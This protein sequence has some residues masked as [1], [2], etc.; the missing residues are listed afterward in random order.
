[1]FAERSDR[2]IYL[3]VLAPLVLAATTLAAVS[4]VGFHVLSGARAYVGGESLWSKARSQTVAKLRA[5]SVLGPTAAACAPMTEWLAVPLGD[6]AARL[7]LDRP[8]P[9]IA[10]ARSGFERGGNLP[11]DADA[12]I[13]LY[14]Y[15]GSTPL[16]AEPVASWRQGD[17]LIEQ[18]R[19]VGARICASSPADRDL[20]PA[21]ADLREL[22]RLDGEFI[23]VE[24]RFSS[25]L[26]QA[27]LQTETFLR[28]AILLLAI[29][30]AGGSAW[31][32]IRSLRAQIR[33]RQ[34]LVDSNTR[35][36]LAAQGAGV[37]LFAWHP[38][39]DS[40]DLDS[41][42]RQIYGVD[43]DSSLPLVRSEIRGLIHPDD[44]A[45]LRRITPS[46]LTKTGPL[47]SR[48]RVF[49][50]DG[51]IRHVEAIGMF[52]DAGPEA[53]GRHMV[54]VIRDVTEEVAA[55]TLHA[56]KAAAE[57]SAQAR[58]EFLSRLSHELRT[59]LNAV[60]GIAQILDIDTQEPLT[61]QQRQRVQLILDSGWHLLRL[62][63]DVLDITSIDAGQV[64]VRIAP[65]ELGPVLRASLRLVEA[66]RGRHDVRIVDH[67]PAETPAVLADPQRL[68]QVFVNL[69]SNA[70]KYNTRGGELRLGFREDGDMVCLS[71]ADDGPGIESSQLV[72]LFQPF[73]RLAR[74]ADVQ[75]TGL[76]LVVVKLLVEQMKGGIEVAS[77]LGR[78]SIFTVR[79]RKAV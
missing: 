50:Q 16:L 29:T 77:E 48:F 11:G 65:V 9:D 41:R 68:Q 76:G 22:E 53:G 58:T 44:L 8:T 17:E 66:E 2:L 24:K 70:C 12:M 52:R 45:M 71:F 33:Q 60:L 5:R 54:G 21:L 20:A 64:S 49:H 61:P 35:W 25:S 59:P 39:D 27:S 46:S 18:L 4:I 73:R 28:I 47:R 42:A 67:W 6:R 63:D 38:E 56:Q 19:A 34:A 14:R 62:V 15:F 55:S 10:E 75:G 36:E 74:T 69:L 26:G 79:L 13:D 23:A 57:R 30:L 78:G 3:R 51:S 72:E 40:T 1:M 31:Y 32:V 43:A 37:G 7:A